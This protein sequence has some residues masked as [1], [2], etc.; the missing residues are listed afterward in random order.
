MPLN[1]LCIRLF[2]IDTNSIEYKLPYL[3]SQPIATKIT[4]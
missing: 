2:D 3:L 1:N 4:L